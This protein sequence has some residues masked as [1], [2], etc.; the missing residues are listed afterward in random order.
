MA[1]LESQAPWYVV[2]DAVWLMDLWFRRD[3]DVI[4]LGPFW[5][6]GYEDLINRTK[7]DLKNWDISYHHF[8]LAPPIEVLL[9]ERRLNFPEGD[10]SP[11][12]KDFYTR[13]IHR[14]DFGMTIDNSD[15]TPDETAEVIMRSLDQI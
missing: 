4:L 8:T 9:G 12:I 14:P 1:K 13:D 2:E 15:Q 7:R 11:L 5:K 6:R 3:Q 10:S